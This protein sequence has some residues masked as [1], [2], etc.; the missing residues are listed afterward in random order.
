MATLLVD[1]DAK[2]KAAYGK[3]LRYAATLAGD[4]RKEP[5]RKHEDSGTREIDR[6]MKKIVRLTIY[7]LCK[8][9]V[10]SIESNIYFLSFF[11]LLS[12]QE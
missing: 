4:Y 9:S 10:I 7:S 6:P 3:G 8:C 1:L 5:K 12:L 2:L 11:L